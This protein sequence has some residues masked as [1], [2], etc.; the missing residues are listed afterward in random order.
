MSPVRS[1]HDVLVR[2][3]RLVPV[4]PG[5][6]AAVS[7]RPVDLRIADG[8]VTE[9]GL[10]L[11]A[12]AADVLDAAGRWA[13]PGLWDHHVHL[14][15]WSR[16]R[17]TVDLA[18]TTGPEDVTR[19]V[20]DHFAGLTAEKPRLVSGFGYRSG[21]WSRLGTVAE[22]D[23][24]TG[25]VPV[26]LTSGDAHNGWL[27]SA[28]LGRLGVAGVTGPL[29]ENDWFGLQP[30]ISGLL[31]EIEARGTGEAALRSAM[32][33]AAARGITGVVDLEM[34]SSYLQWPSRFAEGLDLL[35]VRAS[36]Y[37]DALDGLLA[38]G[39]R[40]GD[41][42]A[43]GS[44]LLTMG[45]FKVISDGSLNTRTARC[46][47]PYPDADGGNTTTGKQNYDLDEMTELLARAHAG[48]LEIALHAIGDGAVEL[49]L[50]AFAATGV[51]GGIEHAQ[52]VRLEDLPR[53][54]RLGV[55]A[56]VQPAHLLDDRDTTLRLWGDRADRCFALRSMLDAGVV[57]ALGSDAPVAPLDPWLAMAA[58]VHRS[59]DER[60]PWNAAEAITPAE[61]L[62]ASTDRQ[63]TLGVGSRGDVV[64]LDADPVGAAADSGEA[65]RILGG[66]PVAA[67]LLAGRLTH[68]SL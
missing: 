9:V 54:A 25:D 61:A 40:T 11:P 65:A 50:R 4:G 33:D 26:V 20:A 10:D 56:S 66:M 8:V 29:D 15:T 60:E 62:V 21:A 31:E 68:S 27:N 38:A 34:P 24:V 39:V 63:A 67:T 55:R 59:A 17:T 1:A 41:P 14:T 58:A 42:L 45:P 5:M 47:E 7:D 16:T 2:G 35:R 28:A 37:P 43:E 12:V 46:C 53:M 13:I 44:D 22:L 18:G 52:L 51:A 64:L 6:R 49:A 48:G 36:V 19:R 32:A 30:A 57:L 3:V 23:A